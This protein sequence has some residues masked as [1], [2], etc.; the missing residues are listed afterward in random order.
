MARWSWVFG[1]MAVAGFLLGLFGTSWRIL[2]PLTGLAF[3][4]IGSVLGIIGLILGIAAALRGAGGAA[5]PGIFLG[6]LVA[7]H[8]A[9]IVIWARNFPPIHDIATDPANPL[10]FRHAPSLPENQGRDFSYP[11]GEVAAQQRASYPQIEPLHL[12]LPPGEVFELARQIA[13]EPRRWTVT[14]AE[15]ET[16]TIEGVAETPLYRFKDDFVVQVRPAQDGGSIVQMRS[17]SRQGKAD[18][19][20]NA[21]RIA[22]FLAMLRRRAE[23]SQNAGTAVP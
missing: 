19:G 3:S 15:A 5:V 2:P 18:L 13:A 12:A 14:T 6:A 23:E 21:R 8:V 22:D 20:V 7:V 10:V 4:V 1:F 16:L 17:R 11:G 9:G